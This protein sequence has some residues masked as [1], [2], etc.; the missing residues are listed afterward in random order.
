MPIPWIVEWERHTT[1]FCLIAAGECMSE[2]F[3]ISSPQRPTTGDF[4]LFTIL[5]GDRE[6]PARITGSALALLGM[7]DDPREVFLANFERIRKVA[8]LVARKTPTLDPI[9]L[10][11]EDFR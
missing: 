3:E 2:S 6:R 1:I 5:D 9:I 8:Y 4:L 11:G 10:D 7:S